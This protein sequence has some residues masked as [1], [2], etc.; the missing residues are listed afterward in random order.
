MIK[1][2]QFLVAAGLISGATFAQ[3]NAE[4]APVNQSEYA[5]NTTEVSTDRALWDIQLDVDPTTV[6]PALAGCFWTGTEFWVAKWNSDTLFTLDAAGAQTSVFTIPGI[7]GARSITSDGT[8]LY[9]GGAGTDIYQVDQSTKTLLS[10]ISTSGLNCRYLTYDSSLDGGSGGFWTGQYGDD[11]TGVSMSGATLI[12]LPATTHG[13]LGVYGMAYDD[14]TF[15]GPYLWAFDQSNTSAAN[16]VQLDMTGTPT[17][18]SHNTQLDLTGGA[19]TG[20]GGGLWFGSFGGQ[21]ASIGGI[22]QGTSLFVY[23]RTQPAGLGENPETDFSVFPNPVEETMTL[24]VNAESITAV[25]VYSLDGKVMLSSN[26]KIKTFDVSDFTSGV[27][28]VEVKTEKGIAS[29]KFV[30]K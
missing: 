5:F 9:I 27:Y 16:I 25:T 20:L 29:Q 17:G 15:G 23:E 30:K 8:R 3:K 13:L 1:Q 18:N 14:Y 21:A 10:T 12:T 19:N 11:I 4:Y 28:V 6:Y 22:S 7:T 2:V 24:S 26:A